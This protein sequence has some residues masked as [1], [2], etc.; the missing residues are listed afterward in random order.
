M[1]AIR[2]DDFGYSTI[3]YVEN[4]TNPARLTPKRRKMTTAERKE[5]DR[6]ITIAYG[7]EE[8]KDCFDTLRDVKD[9]ICGERNRKL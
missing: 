9:F 6:Q 3:D 5:L 2:D 4:I 1:T 8:W 7:S